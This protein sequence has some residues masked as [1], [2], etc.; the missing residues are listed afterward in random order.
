MSN[1]KILICYDEEGVRES[2]K[3]ILGDHYPL[4][5]VETPEA[6]LQVLQ[7]DKTIKLA[8]L[9]IRMP[10]VNGLELL[11]SIK[12]GFKQVKVI[13]VTG[14]KSVK[15]AMEASKLGAS[16]YIVKPFKTADILEYCEEEYVKTHS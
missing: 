15:T 12:K 7:K 2:L 11:S 5:V 4:I 10:Q 1:S 3:L 6:A 16:G 13:M 8:L 14:Y 9:D